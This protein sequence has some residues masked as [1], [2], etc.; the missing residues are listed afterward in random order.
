TLKGMFKAGLEALSGHRQQA[1]LDKLA[2]RLAFERGGTRLY[3]AVLAKLDAADDDQLGPVDV[4]VAKPFRQEDA[5]HAALVREVIEDLGGDPT[6][7]TPGAN[8]V[9]VQ[10]FGLLQ[11]VTDPRTSVAQ[12]LQSLLAAELIDTA[13]WELLV[14]LASGLGH[15]QLVR[16]FRE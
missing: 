5:A 14:D 2:E 10:T 4:A 8:L 9:G 12:C 15:D 7:M 6:C 11:S 13:A 16:R 1:L 3:D